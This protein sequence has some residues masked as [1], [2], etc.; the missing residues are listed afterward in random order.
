MSLQEK[1]DHYWPV[2]SEPMF[3]GDLQVTILNETR[4]HEWVLTEF[5]LAKVPSLKTSFFL[6]TEPHA[7]RFAH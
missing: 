6:F 1:C 4:S 7:V 3:Y 2:D 5:K